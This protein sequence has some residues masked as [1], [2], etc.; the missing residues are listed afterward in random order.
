MS[1]SKKILIIDDDQDISESMRIVLESKEFEVAQAWS[2]K[3]GIESARKN[4]PDLIILDV[5]MES[6]D[7][8]FE[9][10]R[11]LKKDREFVSIPI[12]MLTAIKDKLGLDFASNAGDKVWLPVDDYMEKPLRPEELIAK[13]RS[14]IKEDEN[15]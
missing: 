15:E 9:V 4:K 3:E 13:V 1:D 7:S 11:T 10:A 14:L 6:N 2:G 12:L 8:G 5:M